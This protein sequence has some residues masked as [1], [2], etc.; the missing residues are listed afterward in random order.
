MFVVHSSVSHHWCFSRP[1]ASIHWLDDYICR[2]MVS[3]C[4]Y[5]NFAH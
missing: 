3:L 2:S 5:F 1:Y 4:R